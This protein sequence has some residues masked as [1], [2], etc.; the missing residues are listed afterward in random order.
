M[1][2]TNDRKIYR[3][4]RFAEKHSDAFTEPALRWMLF[5]RQSNGLAN[6][7]A[8]IQNGRAILID[9]TK[10]F[11]WLESRTVRGAA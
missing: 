4:S 6:S 1:S 3:V 8:V 7:G 11:A 2:P 10:F 5:H 9:E